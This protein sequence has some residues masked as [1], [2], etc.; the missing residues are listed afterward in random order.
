MREKAHFWIFFLLWGHG[1]VSRT[2]IRRPP[3]TGLGVKVI[4]AAA[5]TKAEENAQTDV[6]L[7]RADS[8]YLY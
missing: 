2:E 8:E 5:A 6:N 1:R 7:M 3:W 4:V